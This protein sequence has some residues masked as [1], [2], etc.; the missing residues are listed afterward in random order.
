M[1]QMYWPKAEFTPSSA[2][3]SY[4]CGPIASSAASASDGTAATIKK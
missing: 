3:A 1:K 2:T 4:F